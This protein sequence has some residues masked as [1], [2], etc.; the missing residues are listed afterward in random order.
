MPNVLPFSDISA[1]DLPA[2][3]GKGANLGEMAHAG[4]PVPPGFCVTT[5]AFWHFLHE[6]G[7]AEAIYTILDGVEL[8]ELESV[9]QAGEA[10]RCRLSSRFHARRTSPTTCVPALS[11]AD[12]DIA[13][14]VRSSATAEDL[15]QASF[16]GQ[17]DTYLNV[18]GVDDLLDAVHRCWVSL[19]TDRA[20]TYRMQNDFDH[21]DVAL[22][23]VVQQM[24][25]PEV[26]GILFTAD[27]ISGDRHVASID[28]SYGS[29]RGTGLR[30]GLCR[31]LQSGQTSVA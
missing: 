31:S 17:Q 19:F 9:R 15:P 14:A 11:Q 3:G 10:V 21:R 24:V 22:S 27:P 2:V 12:A 26:S 30:A 28:A 1:R 6:S 8:A 25:F 13:Y 18:R 16:A 5:R 7:Q 29:G 20:I 4:F 23:V